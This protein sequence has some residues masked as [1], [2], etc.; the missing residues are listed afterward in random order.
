MM[1][2]HRFS[3]NFKTPTNRQ[4][5]YCVNDCLWYSHFL[6][7]WN[8]HV[9]IGINWTNLVNQS[10]SNKSETWTNKDKWH[11][12]QWQVKCYCK[13]QNLIIS[14]PI[15]DGWNSSSG[16]ANLSLFILSIY[17]STIIFRT[18]QPWNLQKPPIIY[19]EIL[20]HFGITVDM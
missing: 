5:I 11:Y 20:L 8:E 2:L 14:L 7:S 19:P 13:L 6:D 10:D 1:R 17:E 18:N 4:L 15:S 12:K 16:T 3:W 9:R